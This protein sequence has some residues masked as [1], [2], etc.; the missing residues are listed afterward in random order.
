M[1]NLFE[2]TFTTIAESGRPLCRCGICRRYMKIIRTRP[3][4]LFCPTCNE[5]YSLPQNGTIKL[6][7]ELTCPLDNFELVLFSLGNSADH[8]GMSTPVCPQ[9][10]NNPPFEGY[11]GNMSCNQCLNQACQFSMMKNAIC[12]C[13]EKIGEEKCK[14]H[15]VLDNDSRPNWKLNCNSCKLLIKYLLYII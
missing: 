8:Q 9:C 14:G 15:L 12:E 3:Q 4:R 2:A 1:D 7:K 10:Y 5:T 6:Y 13:P 11:K